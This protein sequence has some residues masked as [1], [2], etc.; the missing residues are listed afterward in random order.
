MCCIQ[1]KKIA[2]NEYQGLQFIEVIFGKY[3]EIFV[4]KF[5]SVRQ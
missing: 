3:C 5:W 1:G 4:Q 2:G